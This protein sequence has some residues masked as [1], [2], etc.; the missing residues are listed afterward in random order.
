MISTKFTTLL[1]AS[2]FLFACDADEEHSLPGV[3][4][5]VI[6][7]NCLAPTSD[8]V[9]SRTAVDPTEY[10]SEELGVNWLPGDKNRCIR[11]DYNQCL[12]YQPKQYRNR[13][14]FVCR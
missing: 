7:A 2:A 8:G 12:L 14:N 9:E 13:L 3:Y 10:L 6:E 4:N 11:K 5:T 1:A